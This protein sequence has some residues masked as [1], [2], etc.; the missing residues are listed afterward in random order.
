MRL[1]AFLEKMSLSLRRPQQ[2]AISCLLWVFIT[3]GR[4][5]WSCHRAWAVVLLS[6]WQW[7]PHRYCRIKRWEE[8]GFLKTIPN[9]W[10]NG[11][12]AV[13]CL[14]FLSH[15]IRQIFFVFVL[16]ASLHQSFNMCSWEHFTDTCSFFIFLPFMFL[17]LSFFFF[18]VFCHSSL[19]CIFFGFVFSWELVSMHLVFNFSENWVAGHTPVFLQ[20]SKST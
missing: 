17:T 15:K 6:A 7:S 1:R 12:V 9:F 13:L 10:L 14:A 11:P 2:R 4:C 3:S 20:V 5:T 8:P 18:L 16:Q 19:C